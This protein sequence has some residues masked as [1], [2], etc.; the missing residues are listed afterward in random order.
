[1]LAYELYCFLQLIR[2]VEREDFRTLKV[3][4]CDSGKGARR[5]HFEQTS[6]AQV[7]H[8]GHAKVPAHRRGELS[9]Q[10]SQYLP[11]VMNY[12]TVGI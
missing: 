5:R 8:C 6:D 1:M 4:L 2:G 10:P 12:L 11:T 3:S 9:H 7:G